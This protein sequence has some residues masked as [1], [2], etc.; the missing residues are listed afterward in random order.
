MIDVC[1][2]GPLRV[3]SAAYNQ[4]KIAEGG[5]VIVI[6]SQ[7]YINPDP[8][9]NTD[10]N[11]NLNPDPNPNPNL[12]PNPNLS[13]APTFAG[14]L[15]RVAHHPE[16]GRGR[17]LRPPHEQVVV[18]VVFY[19]IPSTERMAYGP[20]RACTLQSTSLSN[21]TSLTLTLTPILPLT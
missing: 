7:A 4:G 5:R 18:V 11:P 3:S 20:V 1:A 21:F 14:G 12:D 6:T 17:R 10:P 15:G 2:L 19:Q 13:P 9:P 16:Q 8:N